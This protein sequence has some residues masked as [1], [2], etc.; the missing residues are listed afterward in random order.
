MVRRGQL[1]AAHQLDLGNSTLLDLGNSTFS[2]DMAKLTDMG[3]TMSH[4]TFFEAMAR[5][6]HPDAQAVLTVLGKHSD[7]KKT[8]KAAR[9]A[10]VKG[11][12]RRG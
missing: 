8:A 2:F 10:A 9:K 7:D 4:E 5:L 12:S 11:T 1:R 6:D 3:W